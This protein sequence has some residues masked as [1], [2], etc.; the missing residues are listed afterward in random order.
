MITHITE[1]ETERETELAAAL[2]TVTAERDAWIAEN[3]PGGWIDNLRKERDALLEDKK[4]NMISFMAVLESRD[5]L[6]ADAERTKLTK[7]ERECLL[8]GKEIQRAA[9]ELPDGYELEILVERGYGGVTLNKPNYTQIEFDD[10]VDGLSH[11]I[12]Q[13]VDAARKGTS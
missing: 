5:A 6:K 10:T 12:T 7:I 1:R 8:I 13:A 11:C 4:F 9:G 3:S 2:Q